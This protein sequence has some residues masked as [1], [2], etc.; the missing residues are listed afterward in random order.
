MSQIDERLKEYATPKQWQYEEAVYKY[1]SQRAAARAIG[2]DQSVINRSQASVRAKAAAAGYAPS[3]DMT[4]PAAPGFNIK[5]ISTSYDKNGKISSQRVNVTAE[6]RHQHIA[7]QASLDAATNYIWQSKE[8]KPPKKATDDDLLTTYPIGDHHLGMLAW[9][10]ETGENYDI[11]IAKD[12]LRKAMAYLI[13]IA[14]NSKR[15]LIVVGGDFMH[16]DSFKPV[17]PTHGYILDA[18]NRFPKMVE[19][20]I[21]ILLDVVNMALEKHAM[22]DVI[23][24][25][26]NHDLSSSIWIMN[27]LATAFRHN[28]RVHVDTSPMHFH[29][30]Q[31]GKVMI[32]TH[33]GHGVKFEKMPGI[34]AAD[35][36]KM[37]AETEFRVAW[38]FHVH[39]SEFKDLVGVTAESHGV[40][41]TSDA[42]A[43]Q[44]G[45]RSPRRMRSIIFHKD[46]GE[47]TRH[48]V[49]PE[50]LK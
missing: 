33:H 40:L 9:H 46:F 29:F 12:V 21:E 30:Y 8:T 41:A 23:V 20:T 2:I 4:H 42:H 45:Y 34:M 32:A 37:W 17:T 1:G 7:M 50:M 11:N 43:H 47:R 39:H 13:D 44:L 3:Y 38:L 48:T 19:A 27:L 22:V 15:C 5:G 28:K 26:G 25:I 49:T 16:Y 10:K 18:D 24:E 31:F 36:P 6:S 14:P 35:Q